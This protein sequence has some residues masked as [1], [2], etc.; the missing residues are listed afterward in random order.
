M[1]TSMFKR[2]FRSALRD[3]LIPWIISAACIALFL[4]LVLTFGLIAWPICFCIF[5]LACPKHQAAGQQANE[6]P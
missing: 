5:L 4:A 2:I 6:R 1:Q 3:L